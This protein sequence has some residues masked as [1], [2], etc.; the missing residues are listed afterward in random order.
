MKSTV[1][2]TA[3]PASKPAANA[4]PKPTEAPPHAS[5]LRLRRRIRI[6]WLLVGLLSVLAALWA[7]GGLLKLN[8]LAVEQAVDAGNDAAA[9]SRLKYTPWLAPNWTTGEASFWQARLARRRGDF[10]SMTRLLQAAKRGG[11]NP[12]RVEREQALALAQIGQIDDQLESNL[13]AWLLEGTDS[14]EICSAYA[15]GLAASSRFEDAINVLAA[16]G[17]DYP[18]DPRPVFRHGRILEHQRRKEEAL[19]KYQAAL[20]IAPG[21]APA[22]YSIGR[23]LL[24]QRKVDEALAAFEACPGAAHSI[25]VQTSIAVCKK[26]QAKLDEATNI[27]RKVIQNS[28][29]AIVQAY[30][31]LDE[32]SE[33]LVAAVELGKIESDDGNFEAAKKLLERAIAF[34]QRDMEARYAY[35]VTLRGLGEKDKADE[36]FEY[37]KKTREA[38]ANVN[39]YWDRIDANPRDTEA[40]LMLAKIL[41]E[42][43]S[44]RSGLYWLK[45]IQQYEP[46][47]AEVAA[48]VRKHSDS[49]P[50]PLSRPR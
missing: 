15:N 20:R 37:V 38:L 11:Y 28:D 18:H 46:D 4:T 2:T 30:S 47:N 50:A 1:K 25:P 49:T 42:H 41:L 40:R 8:N 9:E 45:S 31:E 32:P 27:L 33:R 14:R 3:K 23:L 7:F 13:N 29:E 48:L 44:E 22:A 10:G 26:A 21:F 6:A 19:E 35:A 39:L 5:T 43:E 16:W 36:E 34:N 12:K 17:A 24:E